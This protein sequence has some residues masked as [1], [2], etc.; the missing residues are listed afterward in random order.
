MC[1]LTD[2]FLQSLVAR[3]DNENTIGIT[4]IGSYAR[5]AGGPFSDVDIR[6]YVRQ[7]PVSEAEIY[8][9]RYQGGY[10]VSIY[11]TRL[12]DEYTSLRSPQKAIWAVPGLRQS[13]ILLDKDGSIAALQD[14]AAKFTWEPLQAAANAYAS[15]N[16]S[17]FAEEIHKI[18]SGLSQHNESQTL[19]AIGGLTYGLPITMLVQRGVLIPTENAFIDLAQDIAGRSSAWTRQFRLAVGLEPLPLEQPAFT[20]R[21]VAGMRLYCE[22]AKLLQNIL[23]PEEA[24]VVNRTIEI[25]KEAGY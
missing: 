16:L 15:W 25:I 3:L 22:T 12:E 7:V 2:S 24:A 23:L 20:G 4:L 21:A 10:L 14:L 5:D 17:G 1:T 9:M 6:C 13:R 19:N 11:L 18:L 8:S